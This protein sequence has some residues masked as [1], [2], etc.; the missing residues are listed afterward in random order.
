MTSSKHTPDPTYKLADR[1]TTFAKPRLNRNGCLKRDRQLSLRSPARLSTHEKPARTPPS[2]S[3]FLPM[4]L[5]NSL[6]GTKPSGRTIPPRATRATAKQFKTQSLNLPCPR[7]PSLTEDKN[8]RN[9]TNPLLS[10]RMAKVSSLGQTEPTRQPSGVAVGDADIEASP[11]PV[12]PFLKKVHP[13]VM[14]A[15]C[16]YVPASVT[17]PRIS[18]ALCASV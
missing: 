8:S 18:P 12:K 15:A 1:L 14:Q 9:S 6:R 16:V 13:P 3:L 2:T 4:K 17:W 11:D 5:S 7:L 10:E